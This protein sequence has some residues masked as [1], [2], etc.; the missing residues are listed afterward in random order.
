[1]E[2]GK[3]TQTEN[4]HIQYAINLFYSET[5]LIH[6]IW[7]K[8]DSSVKP[9]QQYWSSIKQGY[10]VGEGDKSSNYNA[11]ITVAPY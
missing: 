2:G 6:L 7:N 4:Y 5:R 8:S 3:F 10:I 9:T 11:Q 1:M